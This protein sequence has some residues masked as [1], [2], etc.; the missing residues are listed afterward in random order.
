M[1]AVKYLTA[2]ID[3][4]LGHARICQHN[5]NISQASMGKHLK[6]GTFCTF[7]A[8]NFLMSSHA[9]FDIK[10]NDF[11][12]TFQVQTPQI[13]EPEHGPVRIEIQS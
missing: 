7:S 2:D 9:L 3:R 11:S 1:S 13:Q 8:D 12:R 5:T 10:F 6:P 4:V